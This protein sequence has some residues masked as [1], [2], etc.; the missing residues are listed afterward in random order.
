MIKKLIFISLLISGAQ[1]RA[2]ESNLETKTKVEKELGPEY[3]IIDME[4]ALQEKLHEFF[5]QELPT[6]VEEAMKEFEGKFGSP[7]DL[8][9]EK[10]YAIN[11][12]Y[13]G[14]IEKILKKYKSKEKLTFKERIKKNPNFF[15]K[16]TR[17]LLRGSKMC[18]IFGGLY[19]SKQ[20]PFD[21]EVVLD[22]HSSELSKMGLYQP[23][24]KLDKLPG[25]W[26]KRDIN[27]IGNAEKLETVIQE[28]KLNLITVPNKYLYHIP[29]KPDALTSE[30]YLVISQEVLSDQ[31]EK[32]LSLKHAQQL[33]T[34]MLKANLHDLHPKNYIQQK[35]GTLAIIDTDSVAMPSKEQLVALES[36]WKKRG[37]QMDYCFD[38]LPF[39]NHPYVLLSLRNRFTDYW[40]F[41]TEACHFIEEQL[42][43]Y[44]KSRTANSQTQ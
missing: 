7:Y 19:E 15:S 23:P 13:F 31:G 14:S 32:K 21:V 2:M 1:A 40:G 17:A 12:T 27:R 5:S 36:D 28:N 44:E 11:I 8:N 39:K 41:D 24:L 20:L 30:N 4:T 29:G 35:D 43:E 33:C 16:Y 42:E 18:G 10:A 26:I 34:V 37:F 38:W 25:Y 9:G 6:Q 22:A 3:A